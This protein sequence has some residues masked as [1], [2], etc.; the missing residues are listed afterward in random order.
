M[1]PTNAAAGVRLVVLSAGF[2]TRL[3]TPK[4]LSRIR[5][6]TLLRKT[7][8]TLAPLA[9]ARVIVVLPP[10]AVRARAELCGE[11]VDVVV[12]RRRSQGLS[13]SVKSG[14]FRARYSAAVLIL[15]VDLPWLERREIAR[16]IAR[17]R[18][19]R[20]AV[21]AR[22]VGDRAGTPLVLPRRLYAR[23]QRIG[24]DLGL[25]NLVN[26]LPEDELKLVELPSAA[27]DVDTPEDLR[28][29]RRRLR[30]FASGCRQD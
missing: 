8:R 10:R 26:G 22:R 6:V 12:S 19:S 21:V 11:R 3:G 5:G 7:V 28:R 17:W 23:A 30:A 16:L 4:A 25:R 24:G 9:A 13:A 15:P 18:S 1:I 27:L 2:S 20:R 29:A 14:L